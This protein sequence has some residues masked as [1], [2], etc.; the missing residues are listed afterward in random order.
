MHSSKETSRNVQVRRMDV[1]DIDA[2]LTVET[3]AFTTPWTREAFEAELVRNNYAYYF[4]LEVDEMV[5]GYCGLWKVIDEVQ[6]TNIAILKK[7]RGHSYGEYLLRSI[8]EWLKMVNAQTLSLEVRASNE[9]AQGLYH[10]LG[11]SRVGIRKNYY[12]DNQEDAWVMWVRLND[13]HISN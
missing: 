2:V 6:I 5:V 13:D 7:H 8:M 3:E 9:V 1:F 4:V 10:K 11:F 12:A